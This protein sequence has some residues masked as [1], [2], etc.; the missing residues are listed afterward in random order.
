MRVPA[1]A[2]GMDRLSTLLGGMES[3]PPLLLESVLS[4]QLSLSRLQLLPV[5]NLALAVRSSVPSFF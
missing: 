2:S 3:L 4:L 5:F 1:L